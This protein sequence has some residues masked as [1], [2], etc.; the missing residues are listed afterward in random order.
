MRNI[1]HRFCDIGDLSKLDTSF[2]SKKTLIQLFLVSLDETFIKKVQ[3]FF[4]ENFPDSILIGTTTDG[5]IDKDEFFDYENVVTITTFEHTE[6]KSTFFNCNEKAEDFFLIGQKVARNITTQTTKVIITFA[7]GLNANG[8]DYVKGISDVNSKVIVSGGMAG[9]NG[10]MEKTFVFNKE[11]I[12]SYG[13]V[14]ISLNSTNLEVA[15]SY[16]FDWIPIGKE[17]VVNKSYKNRVY[18]IDGISAVEVYAKYLGRDLAIN[19]LEQV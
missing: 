1:I 17:M 16:N 9:D 11:D 10:K 18:E 5:T 4:K 8:E 19:Y 12:I 14:A 2:D 7:D 6:I 13:V 3:K 15:T